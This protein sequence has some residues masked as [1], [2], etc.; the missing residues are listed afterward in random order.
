MLRI[1][2]SFLAIVGSAADTT[3]PDCCRCSNWTA[4][5]SSERVK[6]LGGDGLPSSPFLFEFYECKTWIGDLNK[7]IRF[8]ELLADDNN[9]FGL[10]IL[11]R[12]RS[13]LL[14]W[15]SYKGKIKGGNC[16]LDGVIQILAN[17]LE[18]T[19]LVRLYR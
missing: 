3:T 15:K 4:E 1:E 13:F 10:P 18:S 12:F 7:F 11:S 14:Y 2:E 17:K 6:L 9:W 16:W 19:R 8:G 5:H